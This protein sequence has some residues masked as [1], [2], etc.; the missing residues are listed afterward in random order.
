[1][2]KFDVMMLNIS[3]LVDLGAEPFQK[4]GL[5]CQKSILPPLD[6]EAHFREE[7]AKGMFTWSR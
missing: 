3:L 6:P 7:W 2:P 1:M 5:D 4:P